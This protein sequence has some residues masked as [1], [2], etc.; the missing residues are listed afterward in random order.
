MNMNARLVG[1]IVLIVFIFAAII[2]IISLRDRLSETVWQDNTTTPSEEHQR[3]ATKETKGPTQEKGQNASSKVA[4]S[5]PGP[6]AGSQKNAP[7]DVSGATRSSTQAEAKSTS[8]SPAQTSDTWIQ[9]ALYLCLL[10]VLLFSV[11]ILSYGYW[12]ERRA[13]RS[14]RMRA[15]NYKRRGELD[16]VTMSHPPGK[17]VRSVQERVAAGQAQVEALARTFQCAIFAQ[18]DSGEILIMNA[19]FCELL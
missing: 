3:T 13:A 11:A 10:S 14:W 19:G 5:V 6:S 7:G 2:V 12:R 9:R 17:I 4:Q 18:S 15:E 8:R 1:I 16:A